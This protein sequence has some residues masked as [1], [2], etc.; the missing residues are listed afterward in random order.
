MTIATKTKWRIAGE[1]INNCN[2]AW[3]CPCQF[4]ALPTTG[5]CEALITW[6]IGEGSNGN[7]RLDGLRFARICSWPG[8]IHQGNG[9]LQTIID[10]RATPEQFEALKAMNNGTEGGRYFEIFASVCPNILK[11]ISATIELQ[12]DRKQR[13]AT[14]R[15]PEIA[16]SR[17]EPIKNPVTGEEHAARIVLPGG[18]EYQ[19]AEMGNTVSCLVTAGSNLTFELKGTYA[20]LNAFDWSNA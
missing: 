4:N 16:E 19:E 2:C 3:G 15:I 11:P 8:A 12:L 7:I 14:V 6:Q 18:F 10:K 1:E 5:R 13:T 9:T 17:T 20:Q